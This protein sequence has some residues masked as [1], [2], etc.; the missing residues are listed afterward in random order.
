MKNVVV[1][2]TFDSLHKGHRYFLEKAASFGSVKV[3]LTSDQMAYETKGEGVENFEERSK[4]L[5]Q[6]MPDLQIEKID[7][8]V[9]FA[10]KED[11]DYIV[12]SSETRTRAEKINEERELSGKN[13]IEIIEID[14]VL[15]KDG[16][17]IS[18]TRIRSGEIDKEGNLLKS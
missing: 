7:D 1:G 5:L 4:N 11:F 15:A 9:G 13:K 6:F 18:S 17:P 16:E 2:G 8:A 14:F 12:V 10:N 3:G